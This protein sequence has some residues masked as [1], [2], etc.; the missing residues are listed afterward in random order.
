MLF[1]EKVFAGAVELATRGCVEEDAL[2]R[3][4]PAGVCST[5]EAGVLTNP[6]NQ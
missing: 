3:V 1:R 2:I 6:L 4:D 5:T